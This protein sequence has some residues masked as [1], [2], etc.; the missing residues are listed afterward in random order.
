MKQEK[1]TTQSLK[2]SIFRRVKF[3]T[4]FKIILQ[5]F[6]FIIINIILLLYPY[7]KS[8]RS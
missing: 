2:F 8:W 7:Y 4:L 3:N 5:L 6:Y 1:L